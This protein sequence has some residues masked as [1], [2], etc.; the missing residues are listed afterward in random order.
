MP[1]TAVVAL[2]GN[3]ITR[4]GQ[5]GTHAEQAA[6]AGAM[7]ATVCALWDAGWGVVVVH[8]NGPQ[9]GCLSI[10]Q[11]A[12]RQTVPVQ[13]LFC[14]GAMTE[15]QLGSLLTLALHDACG[16]RLPAV[17][18]VVTHVVVAADDPAFAHPT[19]PIGPF[20][21]EEQAR[22]LAAERNWTVAPDAERGYRRMVA[23][24]WP[25]R[26]LEHEAITGLIERGALVVAA[27]GGGVPV[28]EDGH[29]YRGVDAVVDKDLAA[30]RL[31]TQ[32]G[33]DALV[34]VTDVAHV[35]L[36]YGTSHARPVT[37]MTADEAQHHLEDH[38]FPDGSM[39]PKVRAAI[40]F[41]RAGG[42]TA[43]ITNSERAAH[44]LDPAVGGEAGEAG[45]AGR[46]MGTRIVATSNSLD[47]AS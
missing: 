11:D 17:V 33:A 6:N 24:P 10:Q 34:M 21:D 32:L 8:G 19:K 13:P 31:A 2:G 7:A 5:S 25:L 46:A 47:A 4:P 29:A 27:G 15:G 39:G 43:V 26:F 35:M 38:Q 20:F 18:S 44:S 45:E 23:S 42:R 14:L 40:A 30:Q 36:D 12:A 3:A 22:R 1:R 41:V 9:V 16:D 37:V 28:I